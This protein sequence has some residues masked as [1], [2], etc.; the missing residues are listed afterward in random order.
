[1][2]RGH[3]ELIEQLRAL[4]GHGGGFQVI[5]DRRRHPRADTPAEEARGLRK[6]LRDEG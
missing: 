5:E 4:M 1:V 2:A 6:R 3:P